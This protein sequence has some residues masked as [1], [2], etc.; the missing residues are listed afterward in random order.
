MMIIADNDDNSNLHAFFCG[1]HFRLNVLHMQAHKWFDLI[2]LHRRAF[3]VALFVCTKCCTF[4]IYYTVACVCRIRH[5]K[6]VEKEEEAIMIAHDH[7]HIDKHKASLL[8]VCLLS[9]QT[10]YVGKCIDSVCVR[11]RERE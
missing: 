1:F 9:C 3:P 10:G 6:N 11:E 5:P 7:P 8:F 2:W 4:W